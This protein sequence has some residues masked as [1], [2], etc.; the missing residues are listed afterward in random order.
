MT[1]P[2]APPPPQ[3][4]GGPPVTSPDPEE[5]FTSGA[6]TEG[7]WVNI[8]GPPKY[9][10]TTFAAGAPNPIFVLPDRGGLKS[11]PRFVQRRVVGSWPDL[12]TTLQTLQN[13]LHS[14]QTVVLDTTFKAESLLIRHLCEREGKL[15]LRTVGGGYGGGYEMLT[16]EINR[17][18]DIFF[19]LNARGIHTIAVHQVELQTVKAADLDDYE[20]TALALQKKTALIWSAGADV[21]MY[22]QPEIKERARIE[23]GKDKEDRV[24]VEFT[25][26]AICHVRST[27]GIEAGNRLFLPSPI[28]YSWAALALGASEGADLRDR[29][30]KHLSTLP[31]IER[32]AADWRLNQA[33]WSREAAESEVNGTFKK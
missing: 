14:F 29:L 11:L 6:E 24:K 15:S 26:R 30:F 3:R 20:R 17:I 23:G 1:R 12:I 7:W 9:G 8:A 21:N 5:L 32:A 18:V 27:A 4:N 2:V 31:T 28:S 16:S 22:V 19:A 13:K 33:G 25:G 10:K